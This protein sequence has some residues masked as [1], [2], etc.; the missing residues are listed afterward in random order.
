MCYN[1][2]TLSIAMTGIILQWLLTSHAFKTVTLLFH[3]TQFFS[4]GYI[5]EVCWTPIKHWC[6]YIPGIFPN[7]FGENHLD[8]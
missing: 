2:V 8:H 5:G 7:E 1:E 3:I 4:I 6:M